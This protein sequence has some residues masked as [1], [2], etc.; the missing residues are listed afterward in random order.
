MTNSFPRLLGD[1]GGTNARFGWQEGSAT[2]IQQV[3]VLPC[4]EYE[5]LEAAIRT[6]LQLKNLPVPPI[7]ALG[8]ANPV[9][10]DEV[11]MT[12]HHWSFSISDMQ[13]RLGLTRLNVIND[14]TALALAINAHARCWSGSEERRVGKECRL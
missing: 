4:A 10:G 11:R 9:T 7:C 13:N 14:F 3:L 2:E 5:T 1:I 8:I 12:N 6:Y